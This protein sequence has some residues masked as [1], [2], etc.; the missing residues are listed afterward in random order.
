MTTAARRPTDDDVAAAIARA[1]AM[2]PAGAGP[3]TCLGGGQGALGW[4][5]GRRDRGVD[6]LTGLRHALRRGADEGRPGPVI[7]RDAP[8]HTGR[9]PG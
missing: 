4:P 5:P 1:E 7:V 8:G 3:G 9:M 6:V 2:P